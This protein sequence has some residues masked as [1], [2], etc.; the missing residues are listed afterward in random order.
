[1]D[2]ERDIKIK[3]LEN[4]IKELKESHDSLAAHYREFVKATVGYLKERESAEE[5]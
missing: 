2:N 5:E 3:S 1:M 4:Q